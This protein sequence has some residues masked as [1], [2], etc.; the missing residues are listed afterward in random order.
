MIAVTGVVGVIVV[1]V[2]VVAVSVVAINC[3]TYVNV[4]DFQ[5]LAL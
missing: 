5:M 2:V 3:F 4:F 1:V